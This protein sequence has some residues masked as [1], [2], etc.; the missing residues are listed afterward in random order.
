[1][2]I[3]IPQL[4]SHLLQWVQLEC[5]HGLRFFLV[6]WQLEMA[7]LIL[8]DLTHACLILEQLTN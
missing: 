7:Q 4:N 8:H 2:L 3:D 1:L 5:I 6:H